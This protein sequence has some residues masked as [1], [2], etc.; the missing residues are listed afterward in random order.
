MYFTLS[1]P[2][3][4]LHELYYHASPVLSPPLT[5]NNTGQCLTTSPLHPPPSSLYFFLIRPQ[6][7]SLCTI[8]RLKKKAERLSQDGIQSLNVKPPAVWTSTPTSS[9]SPF[10]CF[11][12]RFLQRMLSATLLHIFPPASCCFFPSDWSF[13]R[14]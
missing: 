5:Q 3:L 10:L 7:F 14:C 4:S 1:L 2:S 9:S 8:P 6:P 13:F 11:N 12:S